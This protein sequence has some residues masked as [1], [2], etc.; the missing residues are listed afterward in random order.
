MYKN[1]TVH[2]E[3]ISTAHSISDFLSWSVSNRGS[4]RTE[5]KDANFVIKTDDLMTTC[6]LIPLPPHLHQSHMT[7]EWAVID[8]T[9]QYISFQEP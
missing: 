4:G 7:A 1:I 3:I 5:Y 6:K 8:N 2:L 9:R